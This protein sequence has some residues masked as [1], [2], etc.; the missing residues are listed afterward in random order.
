MYRAP[1]SYRDQLTVSRHNS[2]ECDELSDQYHAWFFSALAS[3][4]VRSIS[5]GSL[6]H[7]QVKMGETH[8]PEAANYF[9]VQILSA[10]RPSHLPTEKDPII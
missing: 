10:I 5:V 2:V 3:V 7:I 4:Y 1:S 9:V 8:M 6:T